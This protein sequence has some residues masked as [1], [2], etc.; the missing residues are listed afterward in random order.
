LS[1]PYST[2][3]STHYLH[4]WNFMSRGKKSEDIIESSSGLSFMA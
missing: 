3:E 2:Q 1:F 4:N